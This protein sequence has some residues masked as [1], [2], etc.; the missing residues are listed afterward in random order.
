MEDQDLVKKLKNLRKK[1]RSAATKEGK[2]CDYFRERNALHSAEKSMG[3]WIGT[4]GCA[5]NLDRLIRELENEK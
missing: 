4:T 1:W 2:R 5:N 3:I